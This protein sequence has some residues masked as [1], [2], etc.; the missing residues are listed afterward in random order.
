M[1]KNRHLFN[2]EYNF[3]ARELV[4]NTGYADVVIAEITA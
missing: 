3:L 2:E 1:T 4:V